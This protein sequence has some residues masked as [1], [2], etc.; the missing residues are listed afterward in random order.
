MHW[1]QKMYTFVHFLHA[2]AWAVGLHDLGHVYYYLIIWS[3]FAGEHQHSF[4]LPQSTVISSISHHPSLHL[5]AVSSLSYHHPVSL[6]THH[7]WLSHLLV[8]Y[9][10]K[11]TAHAHYALLCCVSVWH[12][13]V[14]FFLHMKQAVTLWYFTIAARFCICIMHTGLR[15]IWTLWSQIACAPH[16]HKLHVLCI[17]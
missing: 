5:L 1:L 4:S 10:H 3:N 7:Q 15:S 2:K 9:W 17:N 12:H 8:C 6:L 14:C 13:S 16:R 11:L